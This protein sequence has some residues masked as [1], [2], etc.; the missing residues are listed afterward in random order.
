[1]RSSALH[2]RR[3]NPVITLLDIDN[4]H[5][6]ASIS[7]WGG[8]VL[9]FKPRH[10]Q[11]ER[12]FVSEQTRW[13]GSKSLRG[14][15]PVC[16]PWFGAHKQNPGYPAH[17]YV[18]NRPWQLLASSDEAAHTRLLLQAVDTQHAGFDGSASLQLEVLAG[19]EL[20]LHLTT[21]NTGT[22]PCR[23][24]AALHSYFSVA[25]V[26]QSSLRGLSGTYSD[27]T[28]NW[29]LLQT[30]E[31]YRFSGE[32]DRIHLHAAP[33]VGIVEPHCE[34]LIR[35]AGHDSIVVWNPWA[36]GS[37]HFPDLGADAWT[38]MLCVETALTQGLELMPGQRHTLTQTIA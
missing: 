26:R 33:V 17:G 5:A 24:T 10:D 2:E 28:R 34:T 19:R 31:A 30:P 38:R 11:R 29:D 25:D 27:K 1:M 12:L 8:Q 23:I 37:V 3:L 4:A 15:V 21:C 22:A 9:A 16:W 18:R 36:S 13:D 32:T 14:G 7:L 35:S 20:T 6:S